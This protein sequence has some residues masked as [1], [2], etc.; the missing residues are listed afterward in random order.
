MSRIRSGVL[1]YAIVAVLSILPIGCSQ[2]ASEPLPPVLKIG[3]LP[4]ESRE[5]LI[6]QYEPLRKHL[7]E[8]LGLP[9]ELIFPDSYDALVETFGAG[10]V[11]LAYFGGLTFVKARVAYDAT[12][13][14]MRDV[15]TQFT[16]YFIVRA[17]SKGM[18]IDDF[19]G[20][21]LAFGSRRST[22][23]HL[24]PRH[25]LI[26]KDITPEIFFGAVQYSGAHDTTVEWV[27]DGTVDIGAVNA[28]I[29]RTM[30]ADGRI[31]RDIFRIVCETRPYIDYVWA[32]QASMDDTGKKKLRDAF[33]ALSPSREEHEAILQNLGANGFLPAS[34]KSFIDLEKI[35]TALELL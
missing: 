6:E 12:P 28:L 27:R 16:S 19:E 14:V 11:D 21:A 9:C 30:A 32:V 31:N 23:G 29:F 17:D 26:S 4:D 18:R 5:K 34:A 15:D 13:L 1:P 3:I 8:S 33:M 7:S 20:Q 24:M 22:S 35:A 10:A 25:Y 2:R